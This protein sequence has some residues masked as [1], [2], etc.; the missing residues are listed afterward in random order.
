MFSKLEKY[1]RQT[2]FELFGKENE[3]EFENIRVVNYQLSTNIVTNRSSIIEK[4]VD[5]LQ[6]IV[7]IDSLNVA[8]EDPSVFTHYPS[9]KILDK[10]HYIAFSV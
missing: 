2:L 10:G 3:L 5:P 6:D 9:M 1:W 4:L 8:E 7:K